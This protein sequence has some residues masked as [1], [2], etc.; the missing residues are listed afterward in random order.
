MISEVISEE[1]KHI[2]AVAKRESRNE[3]L[4]AIKGLK[5][6]ISVTASPNELSVSARRRITLE[7]YTHKSIIPA[8]ITDGE[9]PVSAI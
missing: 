5:R 4:P 2:A 6:R 8:R 9:K 3:T 1:A 7:R